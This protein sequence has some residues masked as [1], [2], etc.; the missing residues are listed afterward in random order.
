MKNKV[1]HAELLLLTRQKATSPFLHLRLKIEK[2]FQRAIGRAA[3]FSH[4]SGREI[5]RSGM[6]AGINFNK[7]I[8]NAFLSL[9]I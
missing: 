3:P 5:L 8:C 2:W 1:L 9:K 7:K 4:F 6:L